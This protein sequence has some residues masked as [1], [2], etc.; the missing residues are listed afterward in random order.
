MLPAETQMGGDNVV[1]AGRPRPADVVVS[2]DLGVAW[3][4]PPARGSAGTG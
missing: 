1:A 2:H 3:P 4:G